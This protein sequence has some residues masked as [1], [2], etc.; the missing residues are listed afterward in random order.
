MDDE[1]RIDIL[2]NALTLNEKFRLMSGD[3]PFT[4]VPIPRLNIPAFGMTDGPHGIGYHSGNHFMGTYFPAT[5]GLAATWDPEL[6]EIYGEALGQK[7]EHQ[8]AI[9]LWA[10]E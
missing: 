8:V 4:T 6:I 2:L 5:I 10:L 1:E 3:T 7:F 9:L